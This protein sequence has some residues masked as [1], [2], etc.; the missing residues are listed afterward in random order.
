MGKCCIKIAHAA[1]TQFK[2]K[3]ENIAIE[4]GLLTIDNEIDKNY[5]LFV[6]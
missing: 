2:L 5:V 6:I 4:A 3:T 1:T